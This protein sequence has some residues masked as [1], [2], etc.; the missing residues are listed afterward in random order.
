MLQLW[1]KSNY[2]VYS[3]VAICHMESS[4]VLNL[5]RHAI[6]NKRSCTRKKKQC[7][8]TSGIIQHGYFP[9]NVKTNNLHH[10]CTYSIRDT[11]SIS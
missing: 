10:G 4:C 9:C 1:K 7:T 11:N 6:I 2:E 3:H 5:V 8:V